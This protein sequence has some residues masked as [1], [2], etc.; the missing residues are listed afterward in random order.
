MNGP[1]AQ[2]IGYHQLSTNPVRCTN[3]RPRRG[4][5]TYHRLSSVNGSELHCSTTQFTH[6]G[7]TEVKGSADWAH[8]LAQP[9]RQVGYGRVEPR[10][11]RLSTVFALVEVEPTRVPTRGIDPAYSA[12][13]AVSTAERV[14]DNAWSRAP[15]PGYR[16]C[17]LDMRFW[18]GPHPHAVRRRYGV[19][20]VAFGVQTGYC[21]PIRLTARPCPV[22][23]RTVWV[24]VPVGAPYRRW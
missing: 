4:G 1:A 9:R 3:G 14:S 19:G 10:T 22:T 5:L 17:P 18:Y 21:G 6:R 13:E 8:A 12:W 2:C 23:A 11:E 24:R 15:V 20:S 16:E 7:I